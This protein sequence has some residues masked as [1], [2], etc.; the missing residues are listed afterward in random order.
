MTGS[1]D[2]LAANEEFYRA[3]AEG[4]VQAMAAIWAETVSVTCIHP[5]W[6]AILGREEVLASWRDILESPPAIAC[7]GE[8]VI[9]HD[10]TAVVLCEEIIDEARLAATNIFVFE[11]DAWRL[12][13]HQAS[14][15]APLVGHEEGPSR[16]LH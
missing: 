6:R 3:F 1:E 7:R 5:G 14:P 16:E 15:M 9:R 11:A 8:Q 10:G 12:V 4:D 13:H 2:V